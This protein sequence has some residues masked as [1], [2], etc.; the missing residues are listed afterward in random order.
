MFHIAT[1]HGNMVIY[2]RT[3][4]MLQVL[5]VYFQDFQPTSSVSCLSLEFAGVVANLMTPLSHV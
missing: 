5:A 3:D 4:Q 2:Y 1:C